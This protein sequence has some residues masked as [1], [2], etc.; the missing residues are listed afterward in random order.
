MKDELAKKF[1]F[2]NR[3]SDYYANS[4]MYLNLAK[5][6]KGK[7]VLTKSGEEVNNLPNSDMRN[8]K[9]IRQ[10]LSHMTFKL[11]FDSYLENG[12]EADNRYIDKI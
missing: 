9:I 10:I 1:K 6:E 4:L 3:Q 5:R 11:I 8:E 2:D 12:V 7:Y